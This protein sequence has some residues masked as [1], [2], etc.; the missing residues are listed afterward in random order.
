MRKKKVKQQQ[1]YK[2]N[3]TYKDNPYMEADETKYMEVEV[4][5]KFCDYKAGKIGD[6]PIPDRF[7]ELFSKSMY[8]KISG[9]VRLAIPDDQEL[10]GT[11]IAKRIEQPGNFYCFPN[12]CVLTD[13][14]IRDLMNNHLLARNK[15][16]TILFMELSHQEYVLFK[17]PVWL[18][19]TEVAAQDVGR[20]YDFIG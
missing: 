8:N 12:I 4:K 11:L 19:V 3:P 15:K 13:P 5:Q 10:E 20:H 17:D 1:K 7:V 16:F 2:D 6:F 18:V 9:L 14:V